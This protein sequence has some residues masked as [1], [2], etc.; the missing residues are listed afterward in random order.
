MVKHDRGDVV[1][2]WRKPDHIYYR[3]RSIG[4][5]TMGWIAP[6]LDTAR[7]VWHGLMCDTKTRKLHAD[8]VARHKAKIEKLRH[9]PEL[10]N[11]VDWISKTYFQ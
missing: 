8:C 6:R 9:N 7:S 1:V 2:D 5:Q 10:T 4:G 11:L 3:K